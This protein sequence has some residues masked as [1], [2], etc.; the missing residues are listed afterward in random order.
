MR[1]Q[2]AE[3][4]LDQEGLQPHTVASLSAP[5]NL[6]PLPRLH[7]HRRPLEKEQ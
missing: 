5:L 4:N 1:P 6:L 2:L 7:P 3:P